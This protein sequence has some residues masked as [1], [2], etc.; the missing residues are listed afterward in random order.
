[1]NKI[2]KRGEYAYILNHEWG[3]YSGRLLGA[4]TFLVLAYAISTEIALRYAIIII[5]LLQL[6]SIFV[7]KDIIARGILLSPEETGIDSKL[8][9]KVAEAE[10]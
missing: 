4:G 6:C 3:L 2:E 1:V 10:L 8:L 5:A 9:S 7:A